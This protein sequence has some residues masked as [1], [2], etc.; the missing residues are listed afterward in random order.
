MFSINILKKKKNKK[1]KKICISYLY[2]YIVNLHGLHQLNTDWCNVCRGFLFTWAPVSI[3]NHINLNWSSSW[4]FIPSKNLISDRRLPKSLI[5]HLLATKSIQ[6]DQQS[7]FSLKKKIEI[8]LFWHLTRDSTQT[9]N[10][11]FFQSNRYDCA[12]FLM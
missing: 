1:D 10:A 9:Q 5:R 6:I 11:E 12:S 2:L 4:L 8:F 3:Q 7:E